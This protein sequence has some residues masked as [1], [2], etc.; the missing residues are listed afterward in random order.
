MSG[1]WKECVRLGLSR[2]NGGSWVLAGYADGWLGS[3]VG[4]VRGGMG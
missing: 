4:D 2:R 3:W 1:G